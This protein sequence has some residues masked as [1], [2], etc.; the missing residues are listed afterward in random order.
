V[1]ISGFGTNPGA[2]KMFAFVPDQLPRGSALVVVL[3]GCGQT[4]AGYDFGTGWST[5][6]KRYGFTL[7]MPEQQGSNNANTCFNWF[8]PGDVARGRGEASSIRQ[9]VARMV[10]DHKSIPAGSMLPGFPPAAP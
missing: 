1:E 5:L 6:A 7:L 3:H 2:L 4:A 9:M 10:A 8:N